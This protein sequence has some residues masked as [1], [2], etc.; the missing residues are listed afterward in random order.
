MRDHIA[1]LSNGDVVPCCIDAEANLRIG[2]IF[3]DNITDIIRSEKAVKI[4]NGFANR[5]AVE[6]FC[7]KC[8]FRV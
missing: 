1:V 4:K 2:N 6:D 8:G 5:R 3:T 7:K